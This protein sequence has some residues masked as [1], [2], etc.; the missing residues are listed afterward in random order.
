[1]KRT[2]PKEENL[3]YTYVTKPLSRSLNKRYWGVLER[4]LADAQEAWV[5]ILIV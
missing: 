1:M 5:L 3:F 4:V 2:C